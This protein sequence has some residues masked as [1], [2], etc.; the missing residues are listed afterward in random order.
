MNTMTVVLFVAGLGLLVLGAEWLVKGASRLAAALGISPLVIGL[1]VVAYGTSAPEMAVSVKSAWAGQPDLALGNVVGSNIFN[2]LFILG[3]SAIITPLVV[4]SQLIRLD[5]PIMIGVSAARPSSSPATARSG[6]STARSSSPAPSPTRSSRSGRAGGSRPR[7]GRSTGRSSARAAARPA[8]NLAFVAAG[9][10]LLVLGSRWLVNG[11]VAF[12][13][14]LGVSELVI[15]LTIV[16][17][18][19]SLPE[20]ATSILA[21]FRG[22]RDIAVGNV[23]GS[24]IFNILAVLGLSGLVAPAGCPSTAALLR[25]DLPVMIAVAVACLP[26]FASGALDRALGGRGLP[27]L[28]RRLHGLPRPRRPAARRAARLQRGDGGLRAAADR[29]HARPWWAGAPGAPGGVVFG[30]MLLPLALSSSPASSCSSSGGTPSCTALRRSPRAWV[31]PLVIGLTVV[32]WARS[33]PEL[34]VSLGAALRG[35]GDI[36]LGNVV[37]S[38]I[39]NV[40]GVLGASAL[41]A[42]LFVSR[43]LVRLDVPI[44]ITLSGAVYVLALDRRIGVG[45]GL[46]PVAAGVASPC[47]RSAPAV[48]RPRASGRRAR[49]GAGPR[50]R[51]GPRRAR[52]PPLGRRGAVAGRGRDRFAR[53]LG[54]SEL[55]IGLTVVAVGTSLPE[56]AASV[57]AAWRGERDIAVG[58]AIGSNLFNIAAVLGLT[59][60]VAPDGVPV[61]EAALAFDIPVMIAV[62][63]ALPARLLRGTRRA[64][65][66]GG[67]PPRLLRGLRPLPRARRAATRHVALQP[68]D[69][70]LRDS[71]DRTHCDDRGGAGRCGEVAGADLARPLRPQ[72][73]G[74]ERRKRERQRERAAVVAA[75]ARR[76]GRRMSPQPAPP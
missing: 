19:T 2:V 71:P 12:A 66:G 43:R 76:R 4:S 28:L 21:A 59:S 46:L 70:V 25:F 72:R 17:A 39:F 50:R 1:T 40:L 13:Q 60:L 32:A 67:R 57:I 31:A 38:N 22:E 8:A 58:N 63:V 11:A 56:V 37:G 64:A 41:V 51:G 61:A 35:Q 10:V 9:L 52:L 26:I 33:A 24:N 75:R 6:G 42:P 55:V 74:A 5:V 7:S 65:R 15:G 44:L 18:G 30:G 45:D 36:A 49:A 48:E 3:V 27:L 47:S 69:G 34:A 20:V 54:V 23:V 16:A 29:D 62:A 14:A 53:S 68:D 73:H